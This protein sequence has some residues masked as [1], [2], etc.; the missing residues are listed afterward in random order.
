MSLHKSAE[1]LEKCFFFEARIRVFKKKN[2]KAILK[3]DA[4]IDIR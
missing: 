4:Q 2:S 1:C 3:E